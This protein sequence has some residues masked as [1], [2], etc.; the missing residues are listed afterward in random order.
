[1]IIR[2]IVLKKDILVK[3]LLFISVFIFLFSIFFRAP[4]GDEAIL[5]EQSY[6][7]Q[8]IGYVKS[9]LFTGLGY[10]WEFIQYH[11]HKLFILIG[12][13]VIKVFGLTE[14]NLRISILLFSLLLIFVLYKYLN[15]L[16]LEKLLIFLFFALL[17]SQYHF[18]YF[19]FIFIPEIPVVSFGF[20]SFYFLDR[21]IKTNKYRFL[22]I[23]SILAGA[24]ALLHLNGLIFIFS[25]TVLLL[26]NKKLKYIFY[27]L[28]ISSVVLLFYFFNITNLHDFNNFLFQFRNDPNLHNSDF[29]I[30][31]RVFRIFTEHM[32]YFHSPKEIVLSL[33]FFSA[34]I[35]NFKKLYKNHFNLLVYTI[36]L[37]ISLAFLAHD[38]T[39]KYSTLFIP[40]M[41]LIV[42]LSIKEFDF[43]KRYSKEIALFL[44]SLFFIVNSI[45]T[46]GTMLNYVN[47]KTT[48][49]T[50]AD[51]MPK[52]NVK[53][54]TRENF[55]FYQFKNYTIVSTLSFEYLW[56]RIGKSNP[57]KNDFFGFAKTI[58]INYI[59][60]ENQKIN[61][62]LLNLLDFNSL[63]VDDVFYG[64]KVI[65]K[66]DLYVLFERN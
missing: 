56:K 61:E 31:A 64:Y 23:S 7:L 26:A 16:K 47:L 20:I 45:F 49:E 53:V 50:L 33:L 32:R 8:E 22:I 28:S 3:I 36:S 42:I 40:F 2:K 37:L 9:E 12:S 21:F 10:G 54:L 11:Y 14:F 59:L 1:V 48:N 43:N 35:F 18:F 4:N 34:L 38:K 57:Q 15:E 27:Q 29:S 58:N 6:W 41:L 55:Y 62:S 52:K 46:I 5:A 13:L 63:K 39:D 30:L 24:S 44:F 25:N 17:L 60:I 65:N 66:T 19:S 51:L